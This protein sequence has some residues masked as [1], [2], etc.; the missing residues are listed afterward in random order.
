[1]DL[2]EATS[3]DVEGIRRVARAS[4]ATS[5]GHALEEAVREEA[6]ESWYGDAVIA[7]DVADDH[8]VLVVA[9]DE[10]EVVGFVQAYAVDD[11]ERSGRIDWLHVH[12]DRR[13]E[14]IG[15]QL[16]A[17]AET[18]L[19]DRGAERLEGRVL[20]LNED[21]VDFYEEQ[22]YEPVRRRKVEVGDTA[23]AELTYRHRPEGAPERDLVQSYPADGEEVYVAF[24]ES[25]RADEAPFYVSYLDPEREQ[26][27]G[28]FCGNCES[29]Q[30]AMGTMDRIECTNCGNRSQA[31]RWDAAYL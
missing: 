1:M 23:I 5:Y 3:G 25:Q 11:A 15:A 8:A 26:R 31:T 28:W 10:G 24:D 17:R 22:E 6:I 9:V 18:E 27:Y 14:G 21:G 13:G 12:P 29:F 19:L 7:D 2:R 20:A 16:F 30:T 4:L